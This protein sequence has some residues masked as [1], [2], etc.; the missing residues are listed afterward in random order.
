MRGTRA[1][2]GVLL[3]LGWAS[4]SE[5]VIFLTTADPQYHT[6]TPGDNSGWQYE[7]KFGGFLGVPIAP[8]FFITAKHIGGIVGDTFDFHG[9]SYTTTAVYDS[10][11]T[12]DLRI[13]QVAG[14]KPF[15]T[16][17]PLSSGVADVGATATVFGRGTRRGD[18]IVV[19][20]ES[21]GWHWGPGDAVQRWG[22]N[23]V[24]GIAS[25]PD[26]GELLA[27]DFDKPGVAGECHLSAGD[28]GGGMFVLE[29][30]LWR[31]AGINLAVDGP[32]RTGGSGDGFDAALYDMGGLEIKDPE[33]MLIDDQEQDLPSSFYGSR[34]AA[35]LAWIAAIAPEVGGLA[36]ESYSAWQRLYFTPAQIATPASS[37]PAADFDGDGICNLLE[38]ALNLDPTCNERAT[39]EPD[40]G[41]RGLPAVRVESAAGS[42]RLTIEFVRRTSASGAGLTYTAE[43]SSDLETWHAV[44]ST[45][46]TPINPRWE[47][48]KITDSLTTGGVPLRFV[49]LRVVL[50]E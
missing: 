44:G 24:V 11:S 43:F 42:D 12:T 46:L 38:N 39:L 19:S 29:N 5:A 7:G 28:S 40:T 27:C 32:F 16:Y 22:R 30:G 45:T 41:V 49:R 35:S 15:P 4:R 13:W 3:A 37:G 17:A 1:L 48:V 47:R 18:E 14:S 10:P 20:G 2:V 31:L 33:W 25:D 8:C 6:A 9:D 34:I 36:P 21:K 26:Y 50:A 23:T